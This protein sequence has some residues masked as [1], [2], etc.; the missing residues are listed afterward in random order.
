[1]ASIKDIAKIAGV[2]ISTVSYAL[3]GSNK[4]TEETRQRIKKI[5]DDLKYVPNMAARTLKRQRTNIIGVYVTDYRGSFY[6][7]LLD[8]IKR[9]LGYYDYDMIVCS[10]SRS[11]LFIPEKMIDGAIILDST[12]STEEITQ[13]ADEDYNLVVLDRELD[14]S[15]VPQV[16]L[17]NKGGATLAINQLVELGS[18]KVFLI[19]GPNG[20]YDN[21]QRLEASVKELE[22][23]NM[24][25]FCR[26]LSRITS[27][28]RLCQCKTH[29]A[30]AICR[31]NKI[32]LFLLLCAPVLYDHLSNGYMCRKKCSKRI[33]FSSNSLYCKKICQYIIAQASIFFRY[34]TSK[35]SNLSKFWNYSVIESLIK[36]TPSF[37]ISY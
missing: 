12:F 14:Y 7:E 28:I 3:N 27:G 13:F 9:G 23:F 35:H 10:G 34:W 26:D 36:V 24:S 32:F 30:C 15:S 5:A 18:Q 33:S 11:H 25:Y 19:T 17:D 21:R 20:S 8:G 29:Y 16:L 6:G 1:M 31:V 2:S 4:V 22:R 37:I